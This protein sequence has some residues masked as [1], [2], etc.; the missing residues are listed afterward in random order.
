MLC[1]PI[2]RMSKPSPTKWTPNA[3]KSSCSKTCCCPKEYT[4]MQTKANIAIPEM[5]AWIKACGTKG[6]R[7]DHRSSL[8]IEST[9]SS[10]AV[11]PSANIWQVFAALIPITTLTHKA[12]CATGIP[13]S[14]IPKTGSSIINCFMWSISKAA[15][16]N[17]LIENKT[18]LT[19]DTL[20]PT[21]YVNHDC[22]NRGMGLELSVA[23]TC[24]DFSC[25]GDSV[26]SGSSVSLERASLP[27]N[28]TTKHGNRNTATK[29]PKR[30]TNMPVI[31]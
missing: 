5:M 12:S 26:F 11:A 9:R 28:L 17:S 1:F 20:A 16:N 21:I 18:R 4:H 29:R 8:C 24:S 31:P 22:F 2:P 30:A 7:T 25:S 27:N 13:I 6:R 15:C 3:S 19:F 10:G 23:G 14:S